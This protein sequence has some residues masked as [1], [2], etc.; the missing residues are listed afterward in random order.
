[1]VPAIF[2]TRRTLRDPGGEGMHR[3]SSDLRQTVVG[4]ITLSVISVLSSMVLG[5]ALRELQ[6][7]RMPLDQ[8]IRN[9]ASDSLRTILMTALVASVGFVPMAI[10]EGA[11]AEVQRPLATVVIGGVI[12]STLFSLLLLPVFYSWRTA[13]RQ[14]AV[15][16]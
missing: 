16:S 11:G 1:M 6:T 13:S 14:R 3:R 2:A 9:A 4:F 12:T 15:P 10:S 5:T 7:R 8:A